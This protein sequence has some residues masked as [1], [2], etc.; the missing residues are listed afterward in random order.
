[1]TH[2]QRK[3]GQQTYQE[4]HQHKTLMLHEFLECLQKDFSEKEMRTVACFLF[5]EELVLHTVRP[6]LDPSET[7][8]LSAVL[9]F[10]RDFCGIECERITYHSTHAVAFCVR[11]PDIQAVLMYAMWQTEVQWRNSA[12]DLLPCTFQEINTL[13]LV[14]RDHLTAF[15]L[16]LLTEQE[17]LPLLLPAGPYTTYLGFVVV[18]WNNTSCHS[19]CPFCSQDFKPG[20]GMWAFLYD[21]G[22]FPLCFDCWWKGS[23]IAPQVDAETVP[24]HMD[25]IHVFEP[26]DTQGYSGDCTACGAHWTLYEGW[27]RQNDK[28]VWCK[29]ADPIE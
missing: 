17:A 25:M 6:M 8:N 11:L 2:D 13:R 24:A 9:D 3:F 4:M 28:G 18:R 14:M 19:T 7:D 10:M 16:P 5:Q 29:E 15:G 20:W 26:D 12:P 1:M 21:L 27:L 22:G 23:S